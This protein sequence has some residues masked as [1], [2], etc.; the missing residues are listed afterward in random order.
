MKRIKTFFIDLDDTVYST[1]NGIW[2]YLG[3]RIIRYMQDV[4]KIQAENVYEIRERLLLDYGTT[5]RGLIVEYD[6]DMQD[7]LRYVHDVDLSDYLQ[8]DPELRSALLSLPQ[9]KWIFTNASQAH[10]EQV[11]RL[12]GIRDLFT[13]IFDVVDTDP[14][15]K[16][17]VPAFEK[18]FEITNHPNPAEILFIDD[19][20]TNLDTGKTLGMHTLQ[21][22]GVERPGS[23]PGIEKLAC[24]PAFMANMDKI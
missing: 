7:Y 23:H 13:G 18:A 2:P 1:E 16:P 15:C 5:M 6:A 3:D 17:F 14:W 22:F 12:L 8:E 24:L 10:A 11:L 21:I 20:V 4:I 9:E 19:R